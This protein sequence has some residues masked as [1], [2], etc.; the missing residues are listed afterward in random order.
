ML[1][2][3][4]LTETPPLYACYGR[5]GEQVFVPITGSHA[6]RILHGAL[7]IRSG[8][9][10]LLITEDWVQE[11][12]Q[13]FLAMIRSHWRGWNIVLFEDRGSPHLADE[14][15]RLADFGGPP[16][17]CNETADGPGGMSIALCLKLTPE[18]PAVGDAPAPAADQVG[19][20]RPQH[21]PR[22]LRAARRGGRATPQIGI[23]GGTTD[24]ELPSDRGDANP[25]GRQRVDRLLDRDLRG[26][27]TL[28]RRLL[29]LLAGVGT[30]TLPAIHRRDRHR[31][32][33]G[34]EGLDHAHGHCLQH[35]SL[36]DQEGFNGLAEV[37]DEMEAV[38]DLHRLGCPSTN[39]VRIEVTAVTADDGDRRLPCQPGREC[40]GRAVRQQVHDA[41]RRQIDQDGA[42]AMA[43]PPGP[44]VDTNGLE[45]W[46]GRDRRPLDQAEQRG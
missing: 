4:I 43:P 16:Q 44:L 20:R 36:G 35:G 45:G 18:L 31:G 40:G 11:T 22:P 3:T 33:R 7:N 1:E 14:S 15:L 34:G 25:L 19:P 26:M 10:L 30:L 8:E 41:M 9:I 13:T 38:H 23:D 17:A 46:R 12:H 24:A 37:A 27:T 21:L 28:L 2:E 42:I 32:C 6:R 29:Q 39:A 5:I